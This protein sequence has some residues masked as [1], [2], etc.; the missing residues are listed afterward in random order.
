MT[1]ILCKPG[2]VF[3]GF[4]PALLR[5]LEVLDQVTAERLPGA[6][7]SVT[8]TAGSNG[9]HAP[10]SA[11]YRFEALDLRT[12]DFAT[13]EAKHA[14]AAALRAQLGEKFFVDLE[15]EHES[16]EHIHVQLRRGMVY[17]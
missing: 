17:P 11:H 8:I 2:T 1:R 15:H 14:F 16:A 5:L 13:S 4:S 7:P 9:S 10:N 12:K 6:P 3:G